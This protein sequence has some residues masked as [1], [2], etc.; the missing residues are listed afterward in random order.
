M[1]RDLGTFEICKER[2]L[3]VLTEN[4]IKTYLIRDYHIQVHE[5]D[6]LKEQQQKL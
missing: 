2:L 4:W 3:E 6:K 5:E 1:N